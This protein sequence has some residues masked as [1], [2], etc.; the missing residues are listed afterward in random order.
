MRWMRTIQARRLLVIVLIAALL[1]TLISPAAATARCA[2]YASYGDWLRTQ[3][4]VAPDD[5]FEQA[6]E[7]AAEARPQSLSDFLDAFVEAYETESPDAPLS[8]VF[9]A[10]DLSNEALVTYLERRYQQFGG[11]GLV[12]RN[13]STSALYPHVKAPD[14]VEKLSA[15]VISVAPARLGQALSRSA[16]LLRPFILSV[17]TLT[18]AQPLGP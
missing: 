13:R 4:R 17:R 16:D 5:A 15:A 8:A 1:P 11:D 10:I 7:R 6:I 14:R 2:T 3:L 9:S 18:S 12:P